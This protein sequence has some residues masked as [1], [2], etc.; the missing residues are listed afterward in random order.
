MSNY[1]P[2][3]TRDGVNISVDG[4]VLAHVDSLLT[5]NE[6]LRK[7][8]DDGLPCACLFDKEDKPINRCLYHKE[9][10]DEIERLR[11]IIEAAPHEQTCALSFQ[12]FLPMDKPCDCFKSKVDDN[13]GEA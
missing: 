12:F 4:M 5:E 3:F 11:R 2:K 7:I 9:R 10:D 6:R 13:E 8:I 1:Y